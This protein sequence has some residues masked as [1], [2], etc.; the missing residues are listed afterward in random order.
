MVMK[1][2]CAC[3]CPI[4]TFCFFTPFVPSYVLYSAFSFRSVL[5]FSSLFIFSLNSVMMTP[6]YLNSWS[7]GDSQS[8]TPARSSSTFKF[9]FHLWYFTSTRPCCT[10]HFFFLSPSVSLSLLQFFFLF[11][12]FHFYSAD[13]AATSC[14]HQHFCR[15]FPS[16]LTSLQPS[17]AAT[18]YDFTPFCFTFSLSSSD[19][20][21]YLSLCL[22]L[23]FARS[24]ALSLPAPGCVP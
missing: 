7:G 14:S 23:S 13:L 12:N 6:S 15:S 8:S 10:L 16:L 22:F 21:V 9:V 19:L 3:L 1:Y 24:F 18:S 5:C 17:C 2:F 11:F 20:C 4:Q